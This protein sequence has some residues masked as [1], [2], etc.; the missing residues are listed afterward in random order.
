MPHLADSSAQLEGVRW[1]VR[2]VDKGCALIG[3][4]EDRE[5][6]GLLLSGSAFRHQAFPDGKRQSHR[7]RS[8]ARD[9][10]CCAK[11]DN[12]S[13][14]LLCVIQIPS[15]SSIEKS[16]ANIWVSASPLSSRFTQS[17]S[18]PKPASGHNLHFC[19][20]ETLILVQPAWLVRS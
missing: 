6:V 11:Q 8:Q 18:L 13:K 10:A 1:P 19:E 20:A 17:Y 12:A 2:T 16:G 4:G 3:Q 14:C 5:N 15:R 9:K 7:K